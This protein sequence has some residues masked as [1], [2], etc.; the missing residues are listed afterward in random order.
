MKPTIIPRAVLELHCFSSQ[1]ST[2]QSLQRVHCERDGD[3]CCAVAIDGHR[4]G[5]VE[6]KDVGRDLPSIFALDPESCRTILKSTKKGSDYSVEVLSEYEATLRASLKGSESTCSSIVP[7]GQEFPPW[8][9]IAPSRRGAGDTGVAV[10]GLD[11]S[12]FA[13]ISAFLKRCRASSTT[14]RLDMPTDSLGPVRIEHEDEDGWT[15]V[16]VLMPMRL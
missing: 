16:Y 2:R 1:D 6:W 12:Y 10:I 11:A 5:V 14:I 8:R 9:R 15:F 7:P 13:D 4:L 3:D